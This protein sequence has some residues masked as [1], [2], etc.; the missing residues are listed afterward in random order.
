ME[1]QEVLDPAGFPIEMNRPVV[2]EEGDWQN[3]H[4][5]L[6]ETYPAQELGLQG[7]G[8]YN[9]PSIWD[10]KIYDSQTP[11]GFDAIRQNVTKQI[12]SG[13][14]FPNFANE[15]EAVAAAQARSEYFNKIKAQQLEDAVEQQRAK[16]M[17]QMIG[18]QK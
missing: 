15:E 18:L 6:S 1:E 4:T 8:W 11:E 14:R 7:T 10:G 12:E 3:P 17:L 9:V 5:E 16:I 13:F 2:F